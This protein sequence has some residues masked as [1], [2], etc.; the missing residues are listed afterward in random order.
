MSDDRSTFET[1]KARLEDI[2]VQV[3]RKDVSLE[4]SL[5]MLEEAVRLVNR[6]NDLIDQTTW[7]APAPAGEPA[8]GVD[9]EPEAGAEPVASV[10]PLPDEDT[11]SDATVADVGQDAASDA[12]PG[13]DVA[14][15]G[16]DAW[17]EEQPGA[18]EP[19]PE[20]DA[21]E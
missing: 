2:V 17:S 12:D 4:Q 6:C 9:G 20:D 16:D 13:H 15:W 10:E 7:R 8:E 3:R 18:V 1:T 5:D 21:R 14:S 11:D 19:M